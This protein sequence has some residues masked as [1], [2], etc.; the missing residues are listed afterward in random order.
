MRHSST[1]I[2]SV[3]VGLVLAS[4]CT[5]NTTFNIPASSGSDARNVRG[6][7]GGRDAADLGDGAI[8]DGGDAAQTTADSGPSADATPDAGTVAS[9]DAG[10][11]DAGAMDAEVSA[12]DVGSSD[13]SAPMQDAATAS[14]A[15]AL[16]P[17]ASPAPDAAPAPDASTPAD[18]GAD[19][20]SLPDTG[21]PTCDPSLGA[22]ACG[23]V[24]TGTWTY[25]G[26]C[27][28]DP[29]LVSSF[30][31]ACP[32]AMLT[33]STYAATGTL[34]INLVGT[35]AR[36]LT[37][38]AVGTF[39]VP[40][41]CARPAGG[42]VGLQTLLA[43]DLNVAVTCSPLSGGDCGCTGTRT[44]TTSD[45]GLYADVGNV[46]TVN[47]TESYFYCVSGAQLSY[48]AMGQDPSGYNIT[49]TLMR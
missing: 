16:P 33:S 5:T 44:I 34:A 24:G 39:F 26:A 23:G 36:D 18:A 8:E 3:L 38:T 25:T 29:A 7:D 2:W 35:F 40:A 49:Y 43:T 42:C 30:T 6:E 11:F 31:T 32:G 9:T 1:T 15:A 45:S 4:G 20:G 37:M 27:S 48:H 14:D 17:D 21:A 19:A 47:G 41:S 12:S 28:N 46:I 10:A 13:S 22:N